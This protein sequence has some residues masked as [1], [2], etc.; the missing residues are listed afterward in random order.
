M[1]I[2]TNFDEVDCG[3][4][5]NARVKVLDL[6]GIPMR[7]GKFL[8][9]FNGLTKLSLAECKDIQSVFVVEALNSNEALCHLNLIGCS[10]MSNLV[11][12]AIT[13]H[14][15][16]K[17]LEI[18]NWYSAMSNLANLGKMKLD[19]LK[20]Q[21]HNNYSIDSLIVELQQC[22]S[23]KNLFLMH[24]NSLTFTVFNLVCGMSALKELSITFGQGG[25]IFSN[26]SK[27]TNLESV[28]LAGCSAIS[29]DALRPLL[30]SCTNLHYLELAFVNSVDVAFVKSLVLLS[31]NRYLV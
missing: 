15:N 27:L 3:G 30:T 22:N 26:L 12:D 16:I 4:E 14:P 17:T 9:F 7:V 23:L 5:R 19:T 18:S 11:V 1:C 24:V 8:P 21:F 28:N 29:P 13:K 20:V 25:Y 2:N 31:P 6:F 10:K